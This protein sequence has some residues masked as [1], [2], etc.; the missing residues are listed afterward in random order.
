[1]NLSNDKHVILTLDAGGTNFVFSAYRGGVEIAK[2]ITL[3]S[4]AHDL[5]RCIQTIYSGFEQ[6]SATLGRPADAISFAFPGPADYEKGI[7][8]DLPNFKA[9]N[10]GVPLGPMLEEHFGMPVFINNDGN[11]FAYG[12]ALAGFLPEL[13]R[14]IVERGGIKQFRNLVGLTLGTGFGCGIVLNNIMLTG[15]NSNDAGIHNT[16]NKFNAFWNAEESVS[17]RAVRRVYGEA[18]GL[19]VPDSMMPKEIFDIAA[20]K[21]P[22][23]R[24]AARL[25]FS[26]FGEA[27]GN[28]VANMLT[29]IDGIVVIGGGLAAAWEF[30]APAM[31]RE[32]NRR[33]EQPSGESYA[34]LSVKVYDL[35]QEDTF[36]E[37]AVGS[38]RSLPLPSGKKN[39]V[40]DE[41]QRAGVGLSKLTASA[42]IAI[43]A[44]A[45]AV[46]KLNA[47]TN[48]PS[49][50]L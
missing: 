26:F 13:N 6:V 33:Y 49:S 14:R 21:A 39:V 2:P 7:I 25:A 38:V 43:G 19:E 30:F 12:E 17:T 44:N 4:N 45:F 29:L 41:L 11:L 42:A 36:G 47:G 8:G 16:S 15:D 35:E 18:A 23:N 1:M 9:F 3:A 10:G 5:D 50:I 22:G 24:E 34:R 32:I 46:Q 28:S 20:G 27:L 48:D 40:Y 37:F 31:F